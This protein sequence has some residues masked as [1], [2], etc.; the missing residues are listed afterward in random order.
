MTLRKCFAAGLALTLAAAPTSAV[1]QGIGL[2][3]SDGEEFLKA[4]KEGDANK[5]IELANQPGA[6][7]VSYR[8]YGGDTALHLVTRKRELDWVGFLLG[9]GADPNIG[10]SN[11]DTPLI[12]AA[13][14]GFEEGAV[15]LLRRGA[16][17]DGTNRR[18]ET[19]L[20]I[21]VQQRQPRLVE[22]LLES[23]ANPDK[24]DHVTGYSPRDYAK[25][26]TR[27]P[28]LLKLIETIKPAAK[29]DVTGPSIN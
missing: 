15:Q 1:A 21:A 18:G 22:I 19:A 17:V 26:D 12:I 6:R 25:R 2:N 11:G 5:A 13:G 20:I 8:G 4:V 23:G 16:K 10:D 14:I 9:K 3:T 28:Q 7:V 24:A 29:K 27:N